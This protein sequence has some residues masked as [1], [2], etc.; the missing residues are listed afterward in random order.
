MTALKDSP[1]K[2][3]DAGV[4]PKKKVEKKRKI[5]N[6]TQKRGQPAA[7]G[8]LVS[9]PWIKFG[10]H[11]PLR[12]D[13]KDTIQEISS[14]ADSMYMVQVER[15]RP[16]E[17]L[18]LRNALFWEHR[19]LEQPLDVST[20]SIDHLDLFPIE[21]E[22]FRDTLQKIRKQLHRHNK[23]FSLHYLFSS[24]RSRE[25]LI[26]PVEI[27]GNW[28]TIVTR[29]QRKQ[30]LNFEQSPDGYVDMEVTDIAVID[31]LPEGR[32]FRKELIDKRLPA[33]LREGC[34][35]MAASTTHRTLAVPD[36]NVATTSN[37][38][39]QTGLVAYAMSR[40]LIRRLKVCQY[41][42]K[43]GGS[44]SDS[45]DYFWAPFEEYYNLDGYRQSLMAA[46][47]HQ[48]IEGSGFQ[49]RM[50][51]EVPSEDSNYD[52]EL[53]CQPGKTDHLADDEKWDVLQ[54]E[55]HTYT[56]EVCSNL[57][58]TPPVETPE[59]S[60]RENSANVYDPA[61]PTREDSSAV[62]DPA[63]PARKESPAVYDPAVPTRKE[64]S[65]TYDP[66]TPF[67]A[68]TSSQHTPIL[69]P[70]APQNSVNPSP[71][72]M[73]CDEMDYDAQIVP[74]DDQPTDFNVSIQGAAFVAPM[75]APKLSAVIPGLG[76]VNPT[77]VTKIP[78][79]LREETNIL[80]SMVAEPPAPPSLP[81]GQTDILDIMLDGATTPTADENLMVAQLAATAL[82]N[83]EANTAQE[84]TR[85]RRMSDE[86]GEQGMRSPK[87]HKSEGSDGGKMSFPIP[88]KIE[89]EEEDPVFT[90]IVDYEID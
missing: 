23:T 38:R 42:Q 29:T 63:V 16:I 57:T 48:A 35:E 77:K 58:E 34:I 6:P 40:E 41:R 85:K 59:T 31:P 30:E 64:P 27:G 61:V 69:A 11:K 12:G 10:W 44:G 14:I 75:E 20:P 72:E 37:Y 55:T 90:D 56:I 36:I 7:A 71:E 33:I 22:A 74:H 54:S 2:V 68:P 84:N 78:T 73:G 17:S 13:V 4:S 70:P 67:Y 24:I 82:N 26:M 79:L 51:L 81:R 3:M 86:D 19:Q 76:L 32:E 88:V 47:A 8:R 28:I 49:T 52:R 25:F 89:E 45:E 53:L 80:D 43:H 83:M 50:A 21:D 1:K 46:C 60:S 18:S 87:R 62:Y 5:P 15:T 39:W 9:S 65:A 66:T